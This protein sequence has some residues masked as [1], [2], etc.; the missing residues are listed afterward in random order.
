MINIRIIHITVMALC[1]CTLF[2]MILPN[3]SLAASG[4]INGT[5]PNVGT[6]VP[7][8]VPPT[9]IT[10]PP[11]IL[12]PSPNTS[13]TTPT[14]TNLD[15]ISQALCNILGLLQGTAGQA[16]ASIGVVVLGIGIFL[17]KISWPLAVATALGIALI[18]GAG[19]IVTM[20]TANSSAPA[21]S[22]SP[23]S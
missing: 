5:L 10:P 23:P 18:F 14:T 2:T 3:K 6:P 19:T 22:C 7:I 15:A 17:G 21:S 11:N 4:N 13:S 9:S 12:P 1:I 16:I 20:I 8:G